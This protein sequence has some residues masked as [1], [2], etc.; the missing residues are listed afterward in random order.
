MCL[1]GSMG[2]LNELY[3]VFRVLRRSDFHKKEGTFSVSLFWKDSEVLVAYDILDCI[4]S[5]QQGKGF[6]CISLAR[7]HLECCV[8]FWGPQHK[9]VVQL[10]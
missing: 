6:P 2:I 3:L 10:L 1:K 7:P 8:Q 5:G 9:R 4:R